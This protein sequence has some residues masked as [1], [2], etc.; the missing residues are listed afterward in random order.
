MTN[1]GNRPRLVVFDFDNTLYGGDSG[2]Q[3]VAW[4]LR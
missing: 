2:T 1:R 3:I 4:L